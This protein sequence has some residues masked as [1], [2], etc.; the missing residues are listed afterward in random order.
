MIVEFVV[1]AGPHAG[2]TFRFEEHA[3]FLV[4][5]SSQAHF[6]LPD[7]DPHVSR[8][9]LLVEVNPPLCRLRDMGGLNGTVVNGRKV[10]QADL[11]DGDRVTIGVTELTVRLH[12]LGPAGETAT[13]PLPLDP[14]ADGRRPPTAVTASLPHHGPSTLSESAPLVIPGYAVE[15]ELGRGGMGVVYKAAHLG[16][17]EA[18][19]VKTIHPH[20]AA[21]AA[22]LTKFVREADV[23]RRLDHSGVVRFRDSGV[24]AGAVWFAME[25][26]PG[27][28]AQRAA[29]AGLSAGRA[30][31]WVVQALE[32]LAHAHARGFVHRD[33]KPSNL[34]VA[35]G[36]DGREVVKVADFGL[37]RAYE[38]SPLSGLTLT[39]AA[40][41][42]PAFM[43]P[44]QVLDMRSV[45]P[46]A[47]QYA[48]AA[49]LYRL[50][51]GQNVYPSAPSVE[52]LFTRILQT[53]PAPLSSHRPDLPPE[54]GAA[55]H[56]A[57]N[58]S[59]EARHPDC[60][61]FATALRP[62]AG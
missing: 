23:V 16:T 11:Q 29:G 20:A 14:G 42:T 60:L 28:D 62:F 24:A 2:R 43:P 4:G 22:A 35:P 10:P 46:A 25:F 31:G 19:A 48:A 55:V 49:T 52:Q 56:R 33:V 36:A 57:L 5:R 7:K 51:C 58:R 41:G 15:R 40:G 27:A 38:A 12:R 39:G 61:A 21:S 13:L 26:V 8:L 6:S 34:L 32:A 37:A 3:T 50:L 53:E 45:K 17:G 59:P 18:V 47:D 54:L 44:E 9:H 30:V 1:T